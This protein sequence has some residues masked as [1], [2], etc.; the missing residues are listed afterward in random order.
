MYAMVCTR[1]DIGHAVG[2]V[3]RFMSNPGKARWE[4]VKWILRYL[5][6]TI[7]KCLYFGKGEIK[8]EGYVYANFA[9]EVDHRRSTTG[10]T[11]LNGRTYYN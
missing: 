11:T 4:V 10:V 1:P 3:C 7:E 5:R 9:G 8:V 6:G 2:V